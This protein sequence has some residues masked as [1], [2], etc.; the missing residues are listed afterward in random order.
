M[1]QPVGAEER[2]QTLNSSSSPPPPSLLVLPDLLR[3]GR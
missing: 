1:P 2:T 3:D